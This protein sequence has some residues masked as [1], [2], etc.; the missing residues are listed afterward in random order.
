MGKWLTRAEALRALGVRVQTLYAYASRGK[1]AVSRDPGNPRRSLY[2]SEDIAAM[3]ARRERGRRPEA[4]AAGTIWLGEP[5]IATAISTIHAGRLY[6]RGRDAIKLAETATLEDV[7]AVLWNAPAVPRFRADRQAASARLSMR[8][9]AYAA[10]AE[11]AATGA[12]TLGRASSVLGEEAATLMGRLASAFG[13]VPGQLPVHVR[14]A[15]GWRLER[16]SV[17]VIRRALV[18]LADQELTN[19]VFA[20]R[21][22]ASTGASLAACML[23]GIAS[24]AGPLHGGA[25]VRVQGLLKE[26]ERTSA[27]EVIQR[28]LASGWPI[29]GFGHYM[30]SDGDPRAS[31]L[32]EAFEPRPRLKQM[33]AKVSAST[34]LAP[35]IDLALA[36][37]ADRYKL[38]D[39]APFALFAIGRS[40]GWLAHSIEQVITNP[41]TMIRPRARY[42]GPALT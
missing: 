19:S 17:D 36:A 38:P 20:A 1:I 10:V 12:P 11:A 28:H 39:D 14:L 23:A 29:P 35:T 30:Y 41:G 15:R 5:I 8:S 16:T 6:Y 31:K 7:A 26:I 4:I 42:I 2:S 9:R 24:A 18:L 34:G 27:D 21:V 25:T 37:L 22:T 33:I 40:V 32:L 3:I 13:A